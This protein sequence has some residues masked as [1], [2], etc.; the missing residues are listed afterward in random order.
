MKIGGFWVD[1][2]FFMFVGPMLFVFDDGLL[3]VFGFLVY[4]FVG[5]LT[6]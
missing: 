3:V 6:L 5:L 1:I 2:D 4:S